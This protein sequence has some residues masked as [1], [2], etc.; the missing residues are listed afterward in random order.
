M[1]YPHI[2][3]IYESSFHVNRTQDLI[4]KLKTFIVLYIFN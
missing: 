3:M 4:Y 1:Q 2:F